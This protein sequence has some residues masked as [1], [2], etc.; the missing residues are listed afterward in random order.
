MTDICFIYLP[1]PYLKRPDAQLP[2]GILMLAAVVRDDGRYSVEVKNYSSY[3]VEDAI[4]D[5][6]EAK[7][8]G[9]TVTSMEIPLANELAN[10]VKKRFPESRVMMGGPG[11]I[12]YDIITVNRRYY[13]A[14]IGCKIYDTVN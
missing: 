8:Y 11:V 10:G 14:N 4:E 5:L 1:H 7:I 12:S 3:T 2:M 6:P 13:I 9:I